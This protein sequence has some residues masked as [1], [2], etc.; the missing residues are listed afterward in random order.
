[1]PTQESISQTLVEFAKKN[2]L[3]EGV[4]FN[5]SNVLSKSGVDS[6]SVVEIILFIERQYGVVIPDT[7]LIPE[8]LSSINAIAACV[9]SLLEKK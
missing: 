3:A 7:M 4:E 1:M 6:Y 8:N 2:I 5:G 9:H